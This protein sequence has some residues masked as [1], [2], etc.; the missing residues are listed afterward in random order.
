LL[1]GARPPIYRP[2]DTAPT[3]GQ[4]AVV[5]RNGQYLGREVT[6]VKGEPFPPTLTLNEFGYVLRE[7]TAPGAD[8]S[9]AAP[10][11]R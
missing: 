5:N 7:V 8:A 6:C 1:G 2:G 10:R 4:Y 9:G 3:S 11:V